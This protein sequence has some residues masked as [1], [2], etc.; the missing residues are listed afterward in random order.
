VAVVLLA[1]LIVGVAL[2]AF[3]WP[4]ARTAPRDLPLGVAG[5]AAATA[6]IEK[7]L[8]RHAD[9]FDVRRYDDE[10]GARDAVKR[11]EIY[12]AVVARPDGPHMLTAS[13][14]GPVVAQALEK[15]AG[16]PS[17]Q[18]HTARATDVV[19]APD[20]DPRGAALSSSVLPMAIGG[21]AAGALVVTAGLRG[22]RAVVALLGAAALV[23]V[24]AAALTDSWLG[25]LTGDWWAESASFALTS[26]AVSACAAG[27][28]TL[29]GPAGIGLGAMV[30]VLFG[31]PFS[32]VTSAPE[33]LPR[34]LGDIGQWL[35][36]G[37][38][39]TL[40]RSVGFFDGRASDPPVLVLTVW[41]V[42]GL[43]L[44]TVGGLRKEPVPESDGQAQRNEV[45]QTAA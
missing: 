31:N 1:P 41:A 43:V 38:G 15:A 35:P 37:A 33:M 6:P 3:A 30:M 5:P 36:P 9:Q 24:V 21:V 18:A 34:P 25:V 20:A 19:A 17:S 14:A 40:L 16:G 42:A 11:R 32:G 23:G 13:A 22:T 7:Q 29:L 27:L 28:G 39:G 8:G 2:W 4:A 12:G 44:V 45:Q 26:L 10:A